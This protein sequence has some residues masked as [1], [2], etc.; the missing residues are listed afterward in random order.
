MAA[1]QQILLG[2]GGS[3]SDSYWYGLYSWGSQSGNYANN[4]YYFNGCDIDPDDNIYC[5]GQKNR[6][7]TYYDNAI[8]AKLDID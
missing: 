7:H 1:V 4:F 8:F 6:T 5:S 2:M 3:G